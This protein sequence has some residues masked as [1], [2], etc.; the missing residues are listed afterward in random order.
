MYDYLRS[1]LFQHRADG[2]RRRDVGIVVGRAGEA[3]VGRA[4]VEDGDFGGR[5]FQELRDDVAA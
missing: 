2:F 3:V 5:R 1:D 4:E